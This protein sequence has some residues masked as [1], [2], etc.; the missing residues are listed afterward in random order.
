MTLCLITSDTPL[1]L[2]HPL[3]P[4]QTDY[5]YSLSPISHNI[6]LT[7]NPDNRNFIDRMLF[8]YPCSLA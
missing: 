1:H 7:H 4:T 3:L 5:W 8:R 2:R 6:E